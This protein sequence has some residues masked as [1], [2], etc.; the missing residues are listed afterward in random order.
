MNSHEK[1]FNFIFQGTTVLPFSTVEQ[2]LNY[3]PFGNIFCEIWLATDV[4]CCT[5]SIYLVLA[6]SV[7]RYIGVTRPLRYNLIMTKKRVY[8]IIL[9]VWIL[10]LIVS[11]APFLGWKKPK[12][13]NKTCEVNDNVGY[14]LFSTCLSFYIPLLIILL[15]YYRIYKEASRQSKFLK[16]GR[17]TSKIDHNDRGIT[18]RVH[19]GPSTDNKK[20]AYF[21]TF[22]TKH[23]TSLQQQQQQRAD[24]GNHD[25]F[26]GV[27]NSINGNGNYNLNTPTTPTDNTSSS[28]ITNGRKKSSSIFFPSNSTGLPFTLSGKLAKF[29]REQKAAKTLAIVVGCF[30]LCWMP[31]FIILPIRKLF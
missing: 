24:N 14:A 19:I 16:T 13:T 21:N 6:I 11:L 27:R 2:L 23:R 1:F 4:L 31:F 8:I 5:A 22:Y 26:N 29:K 20:K 28:K 10:S 12:T 17:K 18:L 30:I 3:W 25:S 9:F 7:D 15:V